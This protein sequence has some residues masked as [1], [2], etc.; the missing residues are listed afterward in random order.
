MGSPDLSVSIGAIRMKNP[1]MT[2]S[3]TFGFGREYGRIFDISALGAVVTKGITLEPRAGNPPPRLWE[4]PCGILNSIGLQNPGL[5]AFI[6][7]EAPRLAGC[8]VPVI[9]NI[10][11]DTTAEF[12]EIASRL[13]GVPGVQGLEINVSCPNI[14]A[15]GQPFASDPESV[16]RV[17]S[18][19]RRVTPKTLIV[20]L[21]PNVANIAATARAAEMGGAD[22]VS[23]VNTYLGMAADTVRMRPVFPRV[24]AGLS[25]PAIRPLALRAVW[26]VAAAVRIPVVG[27]GGICS[28]RDAVEFLLAGARAV[29]VGTGNFISPTA[30]LEIVAG[31]RSYLEERGVRAV[32]DLVGLARGA[33]SGSAGGAGQARSG[34]T[35]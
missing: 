26:E 9:A 2:A 21:S 1:V 12:C 23:C 17:T 13:E 15:G 35:R 22:A 14:H 11:G 3:G 10:S 34:C 7:D 31:I 25:G 16:Y 8:G 19:V 33:V 30:C 29:A 27:I 20:K 4:V 5:E 6:R 28:A 32:A 24:F 18:S